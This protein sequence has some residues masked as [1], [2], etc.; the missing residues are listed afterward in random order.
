MKTSANILITLISGLLLAR[1]VSTLPY[2]LSWLPAGITS[3]M[4]LLG[5]DTGENADDI[6]TIGLLVIIVACILVAA[7]A[8]TLANL[9]L[10]RR[11][12]SA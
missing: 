9:L 7:V 8:V 1:L 2:E 12:H 4:R 3:V 10:R 5:I 11:R 6:E